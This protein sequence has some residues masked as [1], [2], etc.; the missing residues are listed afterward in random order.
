MCGLIFKPGDR[1]FYISGKCSY[2]IGIPLIV[3]EV[4]HDWGAMPYINATMPDGYITGWLDFDEVMLD[5][6]EEE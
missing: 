5:T 3:K 1:V 2:Y 6:G 4:R